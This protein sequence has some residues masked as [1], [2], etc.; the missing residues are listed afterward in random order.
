[1]PPRLTDRDIERFWSKVK[2]T[3]SCWI[4]CGGKIKDGY[5]HFHLNR[6]QHKAHRIS[7]Q[8]INGEIPPGIWACH[9]CDNPSCVRPDHLF[10]GTTSDNQIDSAKKGRHAEVKKTH[11]PYG[12]PYSADNTVVGR[13]GRCCKQCHRAR[14]R[15]GD[16]HEIMDVWL[17]IL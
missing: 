9:H 4:W 11:C 1:M 14:A 7:W 6:K 13:L 10:L 12:H 5:G 15:I 3:E 2:K 16:I 17:E 8:I